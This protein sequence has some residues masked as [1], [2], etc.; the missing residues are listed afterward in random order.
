MDWIKHEDAV[1][2][3]V[4]EYL[5]PVAGRNASFQPSTYADHG[6]VISGTVAVIDSVQSQAN[7]L[8]AIFA[9]GEYATLVPQILIKEE[10]G[11]TNLISVG[12]RLADA[13]VMYSSASPT[14]S[15]A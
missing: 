2:A 3:V 1:A 6:Y 9:E 13:V 10:G 5:E 7:R 4:T 8:E 11:V 12:H 14:A 15:A